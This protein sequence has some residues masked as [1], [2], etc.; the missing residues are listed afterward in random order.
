MG[1]ISRALFFIGMVVAQFVSFR[2]YK[3]A[4]INEIF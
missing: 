1:G 4:L 2:L 3:A